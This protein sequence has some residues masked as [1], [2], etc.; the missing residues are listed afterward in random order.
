MLLA[1][2]LAGLLVVLAGAASAF[3]LQGHRGAR[4]LAP[5]NTIAGFASA[6]AIGVSTLEMDLA[7]TADDVVV[8]SHDPTLNPDITR[9]ARGDW[10]AG[11]GPAIRELGRDEL[12]H[13]DVGR[14][15][16]GSDYAR[17]FAGQLP[18]DGARIPTLAELADLLDRAGAEDITLNVEIKTSPLAPELTAPPDHFARVLV[19]ELRALGLADRTMIQSF[20]WRGL[21][22]VHAIAPETTTA[23]L[24]VAQPWFDNLGTIDPEPS[25]WLA[26]E[27]LAAHDGSVPDLVHGFGCRVW[28]PMHADLTRRDLARARDL[29]L[30][31]IPWTVNDPARMHRLI[32]WGVDGLITDRPERAREVMAA[33]GLPLPPPREMV[34]VEMAPAEME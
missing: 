30:E 10:L 3:D 22:E 34:P 24:S 2:L 20:D 32:R 26:G 27:D 31:V 4:G 13:Y 8:I 14:I 11:R 19:A 17:R 23:C 12:E 21:A 25:P 16:P 28:S 33:H 15:R 9:D 29:G 1:P 7:L 18:V 6:L 5:E